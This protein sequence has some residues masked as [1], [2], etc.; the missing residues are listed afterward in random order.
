[1]ERH[2]GENR[3]D[4]VRITGIPNLRLQSEYEAMEKLESGENPD[5]IVRWLLESEKA[6]GQNA[7]EQEEFYEIGERHGYATAVTWS[8]RGEGRFDVV[9]VNERTGKNGNNNRNKRGWRDLYRIGVD[10]RFSDETTLGRY[11]NQPVGGVNRTEIVRDLKKFVTKRLP[12]YMA[13]SA[14]VM[15]EEMPFTASGKLDRKRLPAPDHERRAIGR[16]PRTLREEGLCALYAEVLGLERVGIDDNFF[17]LGGHSLSA[18]RLANRARTK[19]GLYIPLRRLFEFPT[20]AGLAQYCSNGEQLPPQTG[21]ADP[22]AVVRS[23]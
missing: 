21:Y 19:L 13:P 4:G 9:M 20:V 2:L 18:T 22:N 14:I 3:P 17:E 15:L 6:A 16:L 10:E 8:N 5:E 11:A 23:R 12:A 7:K 1:V